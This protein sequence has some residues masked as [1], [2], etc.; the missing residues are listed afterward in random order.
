MA[1][2]KSGG[3]WLTMTE[4]T[5]I[6]TVLNV[7]MIYMNMRQKGNKSKW[8]EEVMS[9]GGSRLGIQK[10]QGKWGWCDCSGLAYLVTS[11]R[12]LDTAWGCVHL[13]LMGWKP[14]LGQ[15]A[16]T[17][18]RG[19]KKNEIKLGCGGVNQSERARSHRER[20]SLS[21]DCT[22]CESL[23]APCDVGVKSDVS[24][25]QCDGMVSWRGMSSML[26]HCLL[27]SVVLWKV[28]L[29]KF[30]FFGISCCDGGQV[31]GGE[32]YWGKKS[33]M[34]RRSY[35]MKNKVDEEELHR[36]DSGA[37]V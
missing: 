15:S 17:R 10:D 31:A 4:S 20:T 12:T 1:W 23:S 16:N 27:S 2:P 24:L 14:S 26:L 35:N 13:I 19:V 11:Q 6:T 3:L 21:G 18:S 22:H 5:T 32:Q 34:V 33:H 7:N 8:L 36:K 9:A 28:A 37:D 29:W 25:T 30:R